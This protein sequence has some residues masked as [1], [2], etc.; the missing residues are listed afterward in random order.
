[1]EGCLVGGTL[2]SACKQLLLAFACVLCVSASFAGTSTWKGDSGPCG[3]ADWSADGNWDGG[4]P[5]GDA[6]AVIV[7]VN[8]KRPRVVL[9]PT[10]DFKGTLVLQNGTDMASKNMAMRVALSN[11]VDSAWTVTGAGW[12]VATPGIAPRIGESFT[13]ILEVP[14]GVSLALPETLNTAVKVVGAGEITLANA[15]QVEQ[16]LSFAGTIKVAGTTYAPT[17]IRQ[18]MSRSASLA[19]GQT[20]SISENTLALGGVSKIPGFE[21]PDAWKIVG[22]T[23]AK[24]PAAL[25]YSDRLPTPE[26]DGTLKIVDD[27]AQ[28]RVAVYQERAMRLQD[29]WGVSFTHVPDLPADS[30]FAKARLWQEMSGSFGFGFV[31]DAIDT[32]ESKLPNSGQYVSGMLGYRGS[33]YRGTGGQSFQIVEWGCDNNLCLQETVL[34]GISMVKPVEVTVTCVDGFLT[35]TFVQGEKSIVI[36]RDYRSLLTGNF[37]SMWLAFS[38][39]SDDWGLDNSIPWSTHTI[40]NFRGWRRNCADAN[41]TAHKN[42]SKFVPVSADKWSVYTRDPVNNVDDDKTVID[43]NGDFQVKKIALGYTGNFHS[44]NTLPTDG[45]FLLSFDADVSGAEMNSN[46]SFTFGVV[47]YPSWNS[48]CHNRLGIWDTSWGQGWGGVWNFIGWTDPTVTR[49]TLRNALIIDGGMNHLDIGDKSASVL[50]KLSETAHID[51]VYDGKGSLYLSLVIVNKDN[52][53]IR[54]SR[55]FR[56]TLSPERWEAFCTAMAANNG[57]YLDFR[58]MSGTVG[59]FALNIRNMQLKEVA[60][61]ANVPID[62]PVSVADGAS[63]TLSVGATDAS[64]ATPAATFKSVVLGENSTLTVAPEKTGAKVG[65]SVVTAN[66]AANLT[67]GDG[68]SVKAISEV[69]L[70]GAPE[71]GTLALS[72]DVAFADSLTVV[73]PAAWYKFRKPIFAVDLS[74]STGTLPDVASIRV[75]TDEGKDV[76]ER[77]APAFRN[78]KLRFNFARGL[79]LVVK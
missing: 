58:A 11:S 7:R 69:V 4:V 14:K 56:Q 50:V 31:A 72:G 51:Y 21:Q 19:D 62:S 54:V 47:P 61:N 25:P 37:P 68:V 9:T 27:P 22:K 36:S 63:A 16:T 48:M 57:M 23:W 26:A 5:T 20:L 41:W 73:I 32:L 17:D 46:G 40:K 12:L 76:T 24:G 44:N 33:Y 79:F 71:E 2:A 67:A 13:G 66:G 75:V 55:E 1:M 45:R 10:S 59:S 35:A 64:S 65:V 60:A 52:A 38:A 77:A 34:E 70:T 3:A 30:R 8:S 29:T 78:G 28:M 43:A 15:A 42:A 6:T 39:A 53:G 18:I 74:G 49:M